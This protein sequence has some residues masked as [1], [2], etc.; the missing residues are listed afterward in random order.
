MR[1]F[2]L[3]AAVA[4]QLV[5]Q[6]ADTTNAAKAKAVVMRHM[7]AIGGLEAY[8]AV[9]SFHAAWV[10]Q[11]PMGFEQRGE[12]WFTK[13]NLAYGKFWSELGT[14][15]AGFDGKVYWTL[16]PTEGAR[17]MPSAPEGIAGAMFDP[18]QSF[19]RFDVKYLG[20]RDRA[21]KK[22]ET[23]QMTGPDGQL[24]TQ[25]FDPASGLF[26]RLDVGN[27]AAP[28]SSM[29]FDRYK[30]FGNLQ[31]ATVIKTWMGDAEMSSRLISV[32]HKP[33]DPKRF[34]APDAVRDLARRTP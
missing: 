17:I 11:L 21:G 26:E 13:P 22:M 20:V 6:P 30:K 19:V 16:N 9:K 2:I 18:Y 4:S 24:Y 34:E 27:P 7:D 10:M 12:M 31:Y 5:A 33:V 28:A 3:V 23:L 15:E 25:Y 29:K 8:S 32:D 1:H 14:G